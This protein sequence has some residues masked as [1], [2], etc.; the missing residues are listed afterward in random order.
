MGNWHLALEAAEQVLVVDKNFIK[1]V[2]VKAESLYNTCD[3]E[4]ALIFFYR[5][6]VPFWFDTFDSLESNL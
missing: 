4:H 5:G 6:Q 2:Y 1:A 3:F